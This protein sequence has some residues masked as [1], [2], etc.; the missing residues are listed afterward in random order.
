ML[1]DIAVKTKWFHYASARKTAGRVGEKTIE[2]TFIADE[3]LEQ[4]GCLGH[5][6][7]NFSYG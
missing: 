3:D 5:I 6:F 4:Y 2:T 1:L 7:G